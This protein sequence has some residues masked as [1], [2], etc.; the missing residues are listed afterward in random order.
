LEG[1]GVSQSSE[2][3]SPRCSVN[4]RDRLPLAY[5][6][7]CDQEGLCRLP[8]IHTRTSVSCHRIIAPLYS[9]HAGHHQEPP[10][11][12]SPIPVCK[13]PAHPTNSVLQKLRGW[14]TSST[15]RS[16]KSRGDDRHIHTQYCTLRLL[17]HAYAH[18]VQA[19]SRLP[20]RIP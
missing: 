19:F 14:H 8:Q 6:P 12:Q 13:L 7:A 18:P 1:G 9:S 11:Q 4:S 17:N 2:F 5:S 20:H 3:F 15:S 16:S 10:S